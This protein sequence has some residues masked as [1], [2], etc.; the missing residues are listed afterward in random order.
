MCPP[1]D[2]PYKL[3]I[4]KQMHE[5][6]TPELTGAQILELAGKS[7]EQSVIY[8]KLKGGG[9]AVIN[10]DG[11]VDL[12]EPGVEKFV[13][14]PVDQTE[15][16]S[17]RND[18]LLPPDDVEFLNLSGLRW[19]TS[20]DGTIRRV[21][22]YDYPICTGYNYETVDLNLRVGT[23][24]PDEQIDMVY[25]YPHLERLDGRPIKAL[26]Q[27]TFDGKVW[28]RWSRHR[29]GKNPWKPGED[30]ISTHLICVNEWLKRGLQR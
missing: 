29:T 6:E 20:L 12:R 1:K 25:F 11:V 8:Q 3:Q 9:R 10:L 4:G 7:N 16:Y 18:F 24:Y 30:D 27:D 13:I 22:I 28:Q 26:A 23:N 17:S 5:V 21:V 15:G 2:K 14:V 19:E